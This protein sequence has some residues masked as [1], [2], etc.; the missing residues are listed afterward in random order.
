MSIN[1]KHIFTANIHVDD[2]IEVGDVGTGI[3]RIIPITGGTFSGPG[4]KGI[5]LPGGAD[6]QM[7]RY[8][9]MTEA[10]AHYTIQTEEGVLIY[11]V[12]KGY[13]HGPKEIIDRII[14][15]EEVP[16]GSY[17][18]K[19]APLFETGSEEYAFLNRNIFVGEGIRRPSDVQMKFYQVL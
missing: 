5:V 17:Y 13:R 12:N 1:L 14:Q 9:G 6:Y 19:T 11:V 18:F 3:R 7:I 8:D 15:G 2:P 4:I 10:L 16:I